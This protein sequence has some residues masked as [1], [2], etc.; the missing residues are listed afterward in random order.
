LA[1]G[2]NLD[3][4]EEGDENVL[5]NYEKAKKTIIDLDLTN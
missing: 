5:Y 2:R 4:V 1:T 3:L